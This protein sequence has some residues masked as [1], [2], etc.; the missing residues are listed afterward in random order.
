M[1]APRFALSALP[2]RASIPSSFMGPLCDVVH[3]VALKALICG[4]MLTNERLHFHQSR[5]TPGTVSYKPERLEAANPSSVKA[6]TP[7]GRRLRETVARGAR[8]APRNVVMVWRRHSLAIRTGSIA[9]ETAVF[10][11]TAS[12]PHSITWQACDG[13]PI[14]VYEKDRKTPISSMLPTVI[15]EFFPGKGIKPVA[16]QVCC[17][18]HHR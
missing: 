8:H 12:K 3:S 15:G 5:S 9:R 4:R 11:R 1:G 18:G 10:M 13:S 7:T 17:C 14:T 2:I 6:R 16:A